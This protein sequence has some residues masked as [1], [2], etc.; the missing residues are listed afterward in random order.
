MLKSKTVFV[1]EKTFN[2]V[3]SNIVAFIPLPNLM[4]VVGSLRVSKEIMKR[5]NLQENQVYE[6]Y[7]K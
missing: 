5:Y 7:I 1:N 4:D 2:Y 3:A 6:I